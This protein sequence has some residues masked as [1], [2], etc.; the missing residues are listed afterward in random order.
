[1]S[2]ELNMVERPEQ[3]YPAKVVSTAE[4]INATT[5]TLLTEL[6]A[7][8]PKGELLPGAYSQV[9]LPLPAS[10]KTLRLPS[11]VLLF[12]GDG[13][14]VATVDGQDH[15][16]LNTVTLGRDF[17]TA[18]EILSGVNAHDRVILNPPDSILTGTPVKVRSAQP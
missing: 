8:N 7:E 12:R 3:R 2:A 1:M 4:S 18:V 6:A 13:L 17:G 10:L 9:H 16:Q 11:N 5:R 14:H 15:V